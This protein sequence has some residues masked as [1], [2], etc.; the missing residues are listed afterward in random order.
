M[1]TRQKSAGLSKKKKRRVQSESSDDDQ[2]PRN[3]DD[4]MSLKSVDYPPTLALFNMQTI[5]VRL[6]TGA[7]KQLPCGLCMEE[8]PAAAISHPGLDKTVC[9]LSRHR[10]SCHRDHPRVVQYHKL[11]EKIKVSTDVDRIRVLKV[12][13]DVISMTLDH[14][15]TYLHNIKVLSSGGGK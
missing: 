15:G 14:Q 13:L 10:D 2:D 11:S 6:E 3:S 7:D 12:R 1:A 4:D 8:F 9:R 5:R